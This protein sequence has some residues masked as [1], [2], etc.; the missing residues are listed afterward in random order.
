MSVEARH[1]MRRA[2]PRKAGRRS[3]RP[4]REEIERRNQE[5]LDGALD[6]FLENGFEATTIE[7]ISSSLSMS[8]RTIY[9]RYGDKTALFKAALQRAIDEWIVPIERLQAAETDDLEE[10]LLGIARIWVANL[11]RPAGVRL[12]RIANTEL[13]R[14]PEI[15]DYFLERTAQPT[16]AYL[17]DLFRRRLRPDAPEIPDAADAAAAFL[18]LVVEG[19]VQWAAW[20][21]SSDAEI[22]RQIVYRTRLFLDGARSEDLRQPRQSALVRRLERLEKVLK[23]YL[24]ELDEAG[25]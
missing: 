5:L 16:L 22:D 21:K 6:L 4:T 17:T 18:I 20:Q 15:A 9:A 3:G 2:Q 11:K 7:A 12:V 13:Y 8:R 14:M 24:D 23:P 10:T 1:T 19:S 25:G